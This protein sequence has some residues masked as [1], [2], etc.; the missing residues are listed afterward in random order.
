MNWLWHEVDH[1]LPSNAEGKNEQS[2]TLLLPYN[3]PGMAREKYIFYV[4]PVVPLC[5]KKY[6]QTL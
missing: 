3:L 2:N 5:V 4:K 6:F 1:S